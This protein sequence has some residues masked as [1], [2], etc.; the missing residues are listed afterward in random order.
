MPSSS[1]TSR[2]GLKFHHSSLYIHGFL[3]GIIRKFQLA[4]HKPAY[5]PSFQPVL[6]PLKTVA[7]ELMPRVH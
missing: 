3:F 7:R 5:I 6:H 1:S 2:V 4:Q